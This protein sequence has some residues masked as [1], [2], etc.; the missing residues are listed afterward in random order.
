MLKKVLAT[1]AVLLLS[2]SG[3]MAQTRLQGQP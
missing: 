3:A 2:T 1:G